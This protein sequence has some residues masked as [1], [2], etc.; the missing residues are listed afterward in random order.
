MAAPQGAAWWCGVSLPAGICSEPHRQVACA[1]RD[2]PTHPFVVWTAC[3]VAF[4]GAATSCRPRSQ[5]GVFIGALIALA[6]LDAL[7]ARTAQR[8]R[9]R[10]PRS[11]A[12]KKTDRQL[13]S[14]SRTARALARIM[15]GLALPISIE[16]PRLRTILLLRARVLKDRMACLPRSAGGS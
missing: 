4:R 13:G 11:F 9:V 1:S 15:F 8:E 6:L 2:H 5:R 3:M 16:T 12:C 7:W 10:L 14:S